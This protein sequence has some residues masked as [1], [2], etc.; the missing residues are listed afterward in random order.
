VEKL[1]SNDYYFARK[2]RKVHSDILGWR[3]YIFGKILKNL[4]ILHP[5]W[6]FWNFK[7]VWKWILR[8]YGYAP[9]IIKKYRF[10]YRA[11]IR[12]RLHSEQPSSHASTRS[13]F[14][15]NFSA[16]CWQS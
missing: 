9:E 16:R 7:S 14:P 2:V 4:H 12:V 13:S 3:C 6:L 10:S 15:G 8:L 5:G 11:T 1:T